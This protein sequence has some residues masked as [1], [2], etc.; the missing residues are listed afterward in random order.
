MNRQQIR[1][2]TGSLFDT[3]SPASI[4][5]VTATRIVCGDCGRRRD[6]AEK[7]NAD[8][9]RQMCRVRR[10]QLHP[11]FRYRNRTRQNP[12]R[13]NTGDDL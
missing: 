3:I 11:C 7:N 8:S 1:L 5:A 13:Q 12:K 9:R 6:A 10:P 4:P 2:L